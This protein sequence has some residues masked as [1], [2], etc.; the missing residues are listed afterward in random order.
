MPKVFLLLV[1]LVFGVNG[2][3][4]PQPVSGPFDEFGDVNCEN[5]MAR[6]DNFAIQLQNWPGAIGH[7]IFY[8][9]RVF[10]G[11]LPKQGEAAERAARLRLYL[12]ER[13]GIPANRVLVR[14]GGYFDEWRAE[15]WVVPR[16]VMPPSPS[17]R[18]VPAS[19][20]KFGK[21]KVNQRALRC[22]I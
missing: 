2:S 16:D 9:G 22:N 7:I 13:R 19:K 21:G 15:L 8:G 20:I 17:S 4:S 12:V 18:A 14:E 5:E 6:L 1:L 11:R 10:R 3:S